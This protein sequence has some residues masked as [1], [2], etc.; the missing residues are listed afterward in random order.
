MPTKQQHRNRRGRDQQHSAPSAPTKTRSWLS[1]HRW[2]LLAAFLCVGGACVVWALAASNR[3]PPVQVV[4]V[5]PHDP[6]AY[7]QGLVFENGSLY[8]STGKRGRSTLRRVE[9]ETGRILQAHSLDQRYFGEGIAIVGDRI[10]QLTWESQVGIVYDKETFKEVAR[11]PYGGEGWGITY[12]GTHLI[13][14][15]GTATLRVLDPQTFQEVRRII[16]RQRGRRF[17]GRLN[18]LEYVRGEILA[19]VWY[20]DY[21][22]RISPRTGQV[23]GTIDLRR[24]YP[25][26]RRDREHVMNGIAYDAEKDRLFVTGKNWPGL[27]EIRVGLR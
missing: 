18:E 16:V 10:V 23:I 27:F 4:R 25:A 14:S 24:L 15:D 13:M 1:R 12:D 6:Q 11:F 8:E 21:I 9:L 7:T 26:N 20:K 19:N 5:Y 2:G 17:L 3:A 22:A